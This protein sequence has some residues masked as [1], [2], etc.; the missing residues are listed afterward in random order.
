MSSLLFIRMMI[1]FSTIAQVE[2]ERKLEAAFAGFD[3]HCAGRMT[4]CEEA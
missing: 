4:G 2:C 3:V 1:A